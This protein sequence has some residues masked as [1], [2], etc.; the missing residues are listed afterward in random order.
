M[1]TKTKAKLNDEQIEHYRSLEAALGDFGD[2]EL[3]QAAIE[4]EHDREP[5]H[6]D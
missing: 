4:R 2:T 1:T 6:V 5:E 3:G